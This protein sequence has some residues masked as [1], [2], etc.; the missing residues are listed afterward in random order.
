[1]N[2]IHLDRRA[3]RRSELGAPIVHGLHAVLWAA[4]AFCRATHVS[5]VAIS[6]QFLAPL[7]LGETVEA[8]IVQRNEATIRIELSAGETVA[9]AIVLSCERS[10]GASAGSC[11]I[12]MRVGDW[13]T[14]PA[15]L[16]L[17]G[18]RTQRAAFPLPTDWSGL[19]AAFPAASA[20]LSPRRLASMTALSRLVGMVCPG[21]FSLLKGFDL[22]FVNA[23]GID[24]LEFETCEAS[25]RFRLAG[26]KVSAP[27]LL[28]SVSA[29]LRHRPALQPSMLVVARSAPLVSFSGADVLVVGGSRGAGEVIAK[30]CAASGARVLLTYADGREEAESV[31]REISDFGAKCGAFPFDIRGDIPSQLQDMRFSPTHL[32]YCASPALIR[33]RE[34][35]FGV[36]LDPELS[37]FFV[38]GFRETCTALFARRQRRSQRVFYPS[39][40]FVVAP[41]RGL[42][43][44]AKAKLAGEALCA[45]LTQSLPG[46]VICC[47]RLPRMA[48]DRNATV[49]PTP[50]VSVID[51][52][53]PALREM[54]AEG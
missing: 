32:F 21:A 29:F 18:A 26:M 36:Q 30:A 33:R 34:G 13:P 8:K 10:A 4:D 40:N 39:A 3:A 43:E 22:D 5:P 53:A 27:G 54:A 42:A 16:D 15:V 23:N 2:A 1:M 31:V 46:L 48:T 19:E 12:G 28:G 47:R 37:R 9:V 11:A 45:D 7:Y 49:I 25:E 35:Q 38:E 14:R 20:R 6:A 44:F 50:A 52:I 41:P 17:D 24:S 51:A